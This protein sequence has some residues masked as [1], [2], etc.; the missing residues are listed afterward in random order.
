MF[1]K[2]LAEKLG[3][4]VDGLDKAGYKISSAG[5]INAAG[6]PATEEARD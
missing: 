6:F 2:Y 3:C 5:V 4:E 1:R